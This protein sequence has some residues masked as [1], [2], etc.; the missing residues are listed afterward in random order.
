MSFRERLLSE[1]VPWVDYVAS[2]VILLRD[3]SI[4][5]MLG[6]D[7]LPFET[8]DD[9]VINYRHSRLESALRN[10]AQPGLIY[11]FL[12]CRGTADAGIYP[13]GAFRSEFA[14]HFDDHYF[15]KLFG[16]RFMW[17]NR[18]YLALQLPPR[19]L[20]GKTLNRLWSKRDVGEAPEE[21]IKRLRQI[22][23]VLCEELKDCHPRVLGVVRRGRALFTE[24]AEAVAF[25][26]TGY[27]RQVPLTTTGAS[28][29]FSEPFIV[30]HETFEIRLPHQSSW[31]A[32]LGIDDFPYMTSPGMFDQF[33]GASYRHT[34]FHAFRCLPS[35]D[36][37]AIATRKQNRMRTAGDRA[38]SQANELTEAT[39]LIASNR[40]MIGE[41]ACCVAVFA[42]DRTRLTDVVQ[43]AWGDLSSGGIKIERESIALEAVLFSMIPGNFYL[44]GRQAAVSSRNFAA[45]ASMHNFPSGEPT[46]YWG[47]PIALMRTS[48]GTP[49]F[50]HF[51]VDGV[52]NAFISGETGSGKTVLLGFLICQAERCGAQVILWDKD[53][54]LEALV[55]AVDGSYLSLT[56][57]PGLGSGL[58]PLKR[59]T[60]SPEDLTFLS[61]LIRAC[62]ATPQ[63]YDLTPEEDR[64]LGLAL[65]QVMAGPAEERSMA[66][67]RA[68]LGTDRGGAGARLEKWCAG[69]EFGW[70]LDCERDI[71]EL[72][73][74]V[75]AFDQ[76]ALLD[77]PIACG[78]VMA[79]LF[80]YTGKLVDG[81]RLLFLLDEVWNAL[82]IPQFHAEIHNGLKTWRK[83]NSPILIATQ[84]V[85][86]ALSSPIAHTVRE[87]C[88]T[89][90][91]FANPRAI[92][93]DHGPD[94]M[95]LTAT[96][97]DIIQHLPKG[98]GFFL[99]RQGARSVVVQIP[100]GGLDEL[101]VI[102]GTRRG[103]DAL[104][105][106]RERTDDATGPRLIA[107]YHAALEEMAT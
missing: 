8:V 56:N 91:Y 12:Q 63:P 98:T 61:G 40:L 6:I 75:I 94:G 60:D 62:I 70:V 37:Q 45:F 44:R 99:L 49:Y 92:W 21:L 34:V 15:D 93:P 4:F 31:G 106:A 53:H 64:R 103:A 39:D 84:S 42:D 52:G 41:H 83:Y 81:R 38:L 51:Q 2:D 28:A 14:R 86:D 100:L 85:A 101:S 25:A 7:G 20:G 59:L 36:G 76:S 79:T 19:H 22:V 9:A 74:R 27:W 78:A 23:G 13:R 48:G 29:I 80:H 55:R 68:F 72:D 73:G 90:I 89:Q 18:T 66:E 97:F 5:M 32:C 95:H 30:G 24:I 43:M 82:L 54:G 46:G 105:I 107:A 87:Q 10:A 71:V 47:D 16:D 67:V 35:I 50:F 96:E 104:K 102:S 3:G 69:G 33:L 17:L 11:H 26:M 65:R 57:V 1:Y 77:D 88:P 58:A